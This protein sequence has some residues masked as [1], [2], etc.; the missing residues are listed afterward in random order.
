MHEDMPRQPEP[1]LM[2]DSAEADA[3][4]EADFAEVNRAF[5]ER[6]VELAGRLRDAR[7]VDLGTGPGDIP[8]RLAKAMPS[9]HVTA[10]DA[11]EPMLRHAREAASAAGVADRVEPV[12]ADAKGTALP[13]GAF[14]VVFSNSIL[15]HI[16]DTAAFWAEVRRIAAPGAVVLIRDLARPASESAASEIVRKYASG[17]SELLREEFHR[18]LL[19]AYTPREVRHQLRR[20]GLNTL[21]V[22][23][24]SDRHLEVYGSLP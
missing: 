11:S 19:S 4:A 24:V 20:A 1:E 18:S 5:N 13:A 6:L 15:H 16:T 22:E 7:A 8:V 12:L 14:D 21:R 23:T 17:E 9:W 3:Y 2:D 10:V